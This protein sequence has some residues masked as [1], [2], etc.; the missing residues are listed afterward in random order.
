MPSEDIDFLRAQIIERRD[1]LKDGIAAV[2]D[3][4]KRIDVSKI[5]K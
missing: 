3:L 4:L 5:G 1:F 2:E